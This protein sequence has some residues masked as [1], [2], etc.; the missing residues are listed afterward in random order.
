MP[1]TRGAGHC[2]SGTPPVSSLTGLR[3]AVTRPFQEDDPLTARLRERGAHVL[4]TPLVAIAPVAAGGELDEAAAAIGSYDWVVFTSATA[5]RALHEALTRQRHRGGLP[6]IGAVGPATAAAV[7]ELLGEAAVVV[8]GTHTGG[9]LASALQSAESLAGAR[10]LWPRAAEPRE[11]LARELE[12]AGAE[13][14]AP[15][16]YR[17][18]ALPGGAERLAARMAARE[19][20]VV[21]FTSP[22]AVGALAAQRP[23]VGGV[24]VAVIG[25]STAA[26]AAEQGWP[27]H[28]MP[29]EHTIGAMVDALEA[30]MQEPLGEHG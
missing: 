11:E 23:D 14:H 21:T 28:V 5:V 9:A 16:S 30:R 2:F 10:V 8:P 19:V 6:R 4:Q 3:I 20:D 15:V 18:V 12:A 24:T 22:S 25:P 27:V 29:P 17:T 13:L 1:G 7:L 26:A